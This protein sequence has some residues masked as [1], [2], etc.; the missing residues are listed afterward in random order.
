MHVRGLGANEQ[1]KIDVRF[2]AQNPVTQQQL[3]GT[4]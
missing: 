3:T 1:G 2:L 4:M